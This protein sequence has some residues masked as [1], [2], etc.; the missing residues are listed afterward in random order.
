MSDSLITVSEI[1]RQQALEHRLAPAEKF[2][3]IYSG[4]EIDKFLQTADRDGT[5]ERL[6]LDASRP[7]VGMIGRLTVQKAPLDFVAAA[8]QV[9]H[10]H[11]HA[12]FI[13]CGEGPLLGE[14]KRAIG[15]ESRIKMLGFRSDVPD[16]LGTL[17]LLVVSSLWEGL[18][19]S[20]TEAMIGGV[21]V[22]AT[23]V[24]GIPELVTHRKTGLL[25]APANPGELAGNIDWILSN[26]AAA[27]AMSER[28][29]TQVRR[30]FCAAR[31]VDKI[32]ELYRELLLRHDIS[33][34]C[35]DDRKQTQ[36][37]RSAIQI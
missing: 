8:K 12:Q 11:P 32:D 17:D 33:D 7:I 13:I 31:M 25:S 21:P 6:G 37:P 27:N 5:S 3:T 20:L 18:G 23:A 22:A 14:V 28:A 9:L 1:N 4:I 16:I 30:D 15:D 26:R 35:T 36:I 2:T 34:Y 24:D 29:K 19:R 10:K